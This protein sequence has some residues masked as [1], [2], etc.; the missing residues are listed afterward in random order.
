MKIHSVWATGNKSWLIFESL[1][2][3]EVGF[4]FSSFSVALLISLFIKQRDDREK[5]RK[6]QVGLK[7]YKQTQTLT[8]IHKIYAY[9]VY[10]VTGTTN[11]IYQCLMNID[12]RQRD[13]W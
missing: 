7:T 8:K 9:S 5:K 4:L 12:E 1:K 10:I 3:L 6:E 2:M 11:L 13:G